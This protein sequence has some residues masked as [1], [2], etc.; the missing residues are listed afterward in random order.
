M[1]K[2]YRSDR[3]KK[4]LETVRS[5]AKFTAEGSFSSM[6][7]LTTPHE[8]LF[9]LSAVTDERLSSVAILHIHK[10]KDVDFDGAITEFARLKGR[11]LALSL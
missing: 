4:V 8:L 6:K 1:N 10:H 9:E 2:K 11:R 3:P 5:C 7:R